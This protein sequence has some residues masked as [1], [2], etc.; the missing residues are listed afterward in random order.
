MR[1]LRHKSIDFDFEPRVDLKNLGLRD[2]IERE[3]I[4]EK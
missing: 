4:S 1:G 3:K 2:I